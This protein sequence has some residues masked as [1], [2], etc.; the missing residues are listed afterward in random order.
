[1]KCR[2]AQTKCVNLTDAF[3][4]PKQVKWTSEKD[5]FNP[6]TE[7]LIKMEKRT[8]DGSQSGP[9]NFFLRYLSSNMVNNQSNANQLYVYGT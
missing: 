7:A 2:V 1:M 5:S 6:F 3:K 8:F 9:I 4:V